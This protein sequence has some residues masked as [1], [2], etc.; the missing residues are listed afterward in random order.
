[1]TRMGGWDVMSVLYSVV[2]RIERQFLGLL[3]WAAVPGELRWTGVFFKGILIGVYG[4]DTRL[5]TLA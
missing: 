2:W 5:L 3:T 4:Q 1:M